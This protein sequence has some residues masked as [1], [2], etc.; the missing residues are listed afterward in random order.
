MNYNKTNW[1]LTQLKNQVIVKP[2]DEFIIAAHVIDTL[3][4]LAPQA[5]TGKLVKV[6]G[7]N[8]T[9]LTAVVVVTKVAEYY[10][11]IRAT[12]ALT[13]W[14]GIKNLILAL[15]INTNEGLNIPL[16]VVA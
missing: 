4:L 7:R 9:E 3:G 16:Q 13:E 10:Y 14:D 15:T 6:D 2:D 11:E 8:R 12:P 5:I 1:V